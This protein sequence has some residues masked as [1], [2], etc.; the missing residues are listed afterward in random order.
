MNFKSWH[1]PF[2][3]S[4]WFSHSILILGFFFLWLIRA[5]WRFYLCLSGLSHASTPT[6]LQTDK[7][8]L[9]CADVDT[10]QGARSISSFLCAA[11][12]LAK[13][14]WSRRQHGSWG[15]LLFRD[16]TASGR[17]RKQRKAVFGAPQAAASK[18][19]RLQRETAFI[20]MK[21]WDIHLG[22]GRALTA[23]HTA[24]LAASTPGGAR[25][26][27]FSKLSFQACVGC[28]LRAGET[29][30]ATGQHPAAEICHELKVWGGRVWDPSSE[31]DPGTRQIDPYAQQRKLQTRP[32]FQTNIS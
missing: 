7:P 10:G 20:S 30:L 29:S 3:A 17:S 4:R 18:I 2:K 5:R 11:V 21:G 16:H 27:S 14:N 9:P 24:G 25:T 32:V 23:H 26:S 1:C 12:V 15:F 28:R 6:E 31:V 19:I 13:Q 22:R 8:H